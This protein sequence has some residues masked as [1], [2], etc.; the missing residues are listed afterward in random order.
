MSLDVILVDKNSV[1][2]IEFDYLCNN[3]IYFDI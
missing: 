1:S 3:N 2:V